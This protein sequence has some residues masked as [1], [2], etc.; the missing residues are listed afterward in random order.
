MVVRDEQVSSE[1]DRVKFE[2]VIVRSVLMSNFLQDTTMAE[3]K[4]PVSCDSLK[5]ENPVKP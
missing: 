3:F 2:H 5:Y 1:F 4:S